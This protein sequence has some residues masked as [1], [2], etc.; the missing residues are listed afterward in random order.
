MTTQVVLG[1]TFGPLHDGHREMLRTAFEVGSPTIGIT[2]D[3]LARK[4]RDEPR[5][6]PS[7]EEKRKVILEYEC[8]KLADT[9]GREY[10]I[11]IIDHP[12]QKAV[13]EERFDAIV[14]S[15]E[16][17]VDERVTMIN[18]K[19]DNNGYEPLETVYADMVEA[20]DGKRI[21]S[22]RIING[23]ID[24]HGAVIDWVTS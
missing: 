15:P 8:E 17:K 9:F 7:A 5:Y 18:E 12:I 23:E 3:E 14:L 2:S 24:E 16:G 4:T 6:I 19:R 10:T 22:T 13:E 1:G 20:E 11:A 21:S